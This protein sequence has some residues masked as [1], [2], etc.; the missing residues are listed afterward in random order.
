MS[1]LRPY[2]RL[3]WKGSLTRQTGETSRVGLGPLDCLYIFPVTNVPFPTFLKDKDCYKK[4]SSQYHRMLDVLPTLPFF[5][6][7]PREGDHQRQRLIPSQSY[8]SQKPKY[9]PTGHFVPSALAC[10]V[11]QLPFH[12]LIKALEAFCQVS[13]HRAASQSRGLLRER[14]PSRP[15]R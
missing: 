12:S 10:R 7:T 6:S 8:P 11:P 5:N 15:G 4:L 3:G 9:E 2:C 14:S 13:T 1:H